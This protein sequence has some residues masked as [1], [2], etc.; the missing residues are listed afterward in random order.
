M[1]EHSHHKVTKT[2]RNIYFLIVLCLRVFVVFSFLLVRPTHAYFPAAQ[3]T[4]QPQRREEPRLHIAGLDMSDFPF[5]QARLLTADPQSAPVIDLSALVVRENGVPITA[6]STANVPVGID[7]VFVIDA[8]NMLLQIDDDSGRTRLAKVQESIGRYANN[9]MDPAGLDQVSIVAPSVDGQSVRWIARDV[10]QPSELVTAVNAYPETLPAESLRPNTP[11][12]DMLLEALGHL[13]GGDAGRFRV[14]LLLTDGARLDQQ[15]DF[16]TLVEQ[17]LVA[18]TPF[19]AAILGARADDNEIANVNR[20]FE[21]TR[22]RF[23]HMPQPEATDPFYRLWQQQG[24]QTQIEYTS[25]QRQS[26]TVELSVQLGNVRDST[27]FEVTLAA[28]EVALDGLGESIERVGTSPDT[29]L[30]LLQPAAQP[31]TVL[32]T[33]PDGRPRRLAQLDFLVNDQAQPLPATLE[34]EQLSAGASG[35]YPLIWDISELDAGTYRLQV[36]VE[37]ELGYQATSPVSEVEIAVTRPSPPTPTAAPT[38]A[39]LLPSI[40]ETM[41][42]SWLWLLPLVGGLA[43]LLFLV[44]RARRRAASSREATE[45]TAA[46]LPI[47]PAPTENQVAYIERLDAGGTPTGEQFLIAVSD[48]PG[49]VRTFHNI[50]IGRDATAV[51]LVLDDAG[52]SRLHARI[53]GSTYEGYWLHDEGSAGGTYLN[54]E[55]LGLAPRRLEHGDVIQ[56]GRVMFRFVLTSS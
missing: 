16:S 45:Q 32:V 46:G 8:N 15:L 3:E 14:V 55:R 51:D 41:G 7:V 26:G 30:P 36:R 54:F 37:D 48:L 39:P 20:L 49:A 42:D 27:T 29:L 13:A 33:W 19:F 25:L 5:V 21:P 1:A 22:G 53:H 24:R 50:T 10:S 40:T 9:F 23:L 18:Q 2:Q 34:G 56:F 4:P 52:V 12:N 17:A 28:P 43:L 38:T 47:R 11:L 35:R 44:V 6:Y 31:F